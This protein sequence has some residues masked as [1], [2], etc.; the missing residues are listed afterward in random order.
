MAEAIAS[1]LSFP[2]EKGTKISAKE[3]DT[4]ITTYVH[5]LNQIQPTTWTKPHRLCFLYGFI[6]RAMLCQPEDED[7]GV[8]THAFQ[9]RL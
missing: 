1:L 6:Q 7:L 3:Y 5:A 9:L 4:Q 8:W 2:P